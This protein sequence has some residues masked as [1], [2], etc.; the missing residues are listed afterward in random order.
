MQLGKVTTLP[1][2]GDRRREVSVWFRERGRSGPLSP[3][4]LEC[5]NQASV[6]MGTG[7]LDWVIPYTLIVYSQR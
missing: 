3:A 2:R 7:R 6:V 4:G 1:V 5:R